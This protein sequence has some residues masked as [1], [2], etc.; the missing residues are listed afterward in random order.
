MKI[1]G[2]SSR[3]EKRGDEKK[4]EKK[5]TAMDRFVGRVMDELRDD[6]MTGN[7]RRVGLSPR[8]SLEFGFIM[9]E[10][11]LRFLN[12]LSLSCFF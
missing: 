12:A 5:S 8:N 3:R 9:L 4:N 1:F 11:S 7:G 6:L 2:E 10:L